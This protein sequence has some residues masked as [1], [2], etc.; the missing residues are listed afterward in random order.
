MHKRPAMRL[1]RLMRLIRPVKSRNRVT[2]RR[3][4]PRMLKRVKTTIKRHLLVTWWLLKTKQTRQEANRNSKPSKARILSYKVKTG[5]FG[6]SW[7]KQRCR[8]SH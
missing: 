1:H 4:Q 3:N 8:M 5:D 6:G 7:V 2:K